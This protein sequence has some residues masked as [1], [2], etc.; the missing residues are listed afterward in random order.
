MPVQIQ[1]LE[2]WMPQGRHRFQARDP[3]LHVGCQARLADLAAEIPQVAP[4]RAPCRGRVLLA[5]HALQPLAVLVAAR[6]ELRHVLLR[7]R[8]LA[9]DCASDGLNVLV[10]GGKQHIPFATCSSLRLDRMRLAVV[11][12]LSFKMPFIQCTQGSMHT[13]SWHVLSSQGVAQRPVKAAPTVTKPAP[14]PALAANQLAHGSCKVHRKRVSLEDFLNCTGN[15][16]WRGRGGNYR[17][18]NKH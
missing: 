17:K 16:V 4:Q 18:V 2:R 7:S 11:P 12:K 14:S 15:A 10:Q 5:A 8:A 3:L 13:L 1:L 9:M 6:A